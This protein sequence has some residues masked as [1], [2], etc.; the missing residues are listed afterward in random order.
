MAQEE[1]KTVKD[2]SPFSYQSVRKVSRWWCCSPGAHC[3][4]EEDTG[5]ENFDKWNPG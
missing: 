1:S 5:S 3:Q 2:S 4:G